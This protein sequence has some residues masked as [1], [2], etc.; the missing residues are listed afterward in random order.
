[1]QVFGLLAAQLALTTA[2]AVP[3]VVSPAVKTWTTANPAPILLAMVASFGIL[4]T[5]TFSTHCRTH[6]PLNLILLFSFTAA[7]ASG[8]G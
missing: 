3:F 6:H 4:L 5:F 7:E 1:V 2:I 8:H